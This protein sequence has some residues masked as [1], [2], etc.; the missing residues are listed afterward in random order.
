MAGLLKQLASE[1]LVTLTGPG[2]VGKTR[3]A[4]EAAERLAGPGYPGPDRSAWFVELAPVTEPSEVPHAVLD[5]VGLRERSI[6]RRGGDGGAD[7]ADRLCAALAERDALLIL[8][9]CEHVI[10]AAALLAARLLADCPGVQVL[11]TSREPLRIGGESLHVVAPLP[12]PPA[13]ETGPGADSHSFPAVRLFADRA[14]AVL[15]DFE[16]DVGN[17]APVAQICRTLDGMPLAI[18]LA[19]P[20]LRTLTPA[21]LADRLD[22]RFALLT[23]G[24][25]TSLPRHQ[26]LRATVDWSWQLLSG[27]ERALARRLAVFPGGA[28]LTAAEQVCPDPAAEERP[29]PPGQPAGPGRCAG[30]RSWPRSPA[31]SA[32]RS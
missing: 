4:A 7:P 10:E 8:D 26:T 17:A 28:T 19:V 5:A 31:W 22:D 14:A 30:P 27:P 2:G 9:N 32:S 12:A 20:W 24:S 15:P 13:T 18:E 3:L 11:A 29:A 23:G 25:R 16:L 21:Q 6:A 1:R